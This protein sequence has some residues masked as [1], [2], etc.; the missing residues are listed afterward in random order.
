MYVELAA[1][2]AKGSRLTSSQQLDRVAVFHAYRRDNHGFTKHYE[3]REENLG[4]TKPCVEHS[5]EAFSR[6]FP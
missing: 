1:D 3:S 5:A 2:E 4:G 6:C